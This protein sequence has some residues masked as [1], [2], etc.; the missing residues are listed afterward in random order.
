MVARLAK[1]VPGLAIDDLNRSGSEAGRCVD[2]GSH[3]GAAE[4]KL[5][6]LGLDPLDSLDAVGHLGGVPREFL[7]EPD[8]SRV[9][10]M[11]AARLEHVV[12]LD[13]L[14]LEAAP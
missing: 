14:C 1:R 6:Q 4:G 7:S 13:G 2:A 11:G 8:R 3:C 5:E 9:L 10:E 12:E